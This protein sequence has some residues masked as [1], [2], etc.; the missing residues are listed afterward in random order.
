MTVRKRP[1]QREVAL[2]AGVSQ[3]VVSQVL[4]GKGSAIRLA[5][6]TRE[7]VLSAM[8]DLGYVPNAAARRLAGGL[9]HV[10]GVFTYE[11]LFPTHASDFYHP[12]LEGIEEEAERLGYD[13]L[14]HTRPPRAGAPRPLFEDGGSRLRLADGT[15]LLG[16][17]NA[18]RRAELA[19]LVDEGHPVVFIGRRELPG[20]DIPYVAA[21]YAGATE[22]ALGVLLDLGHRQ[23]AYLG[24]GRE[25]E[26]VADRRAGYERGMGAPGLTPVYPDLT[27]AVF[28][29]FTAFLVENDDLA[30]QLLHLAESQGLSAPRDFS[31]VVL[32]DPLGGVGEAPWAA[33][34]I[35]RAQMGR[36]ALSLLDRQ[37]HGGE[38]TAEVLACCWHGGPSLGP[39]GV[40]EPN[41]SLGS[42]GAA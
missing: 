14:L 17:L 13:L 27:P 20:H 39:P 33:F 4:N 1:T 38:V 12:F 23:V 35:P 37:L 22:E 42:G 31:F 41:Q 34:E 40:T 29:A 19:R 5:P 28:G 3:A 25:G 15:L 6:E 11:R 10:I 9:G 2:R 26:S 8:R 24:S 36:R 21:D 18:E 32:G 7:R 16:E 30:R